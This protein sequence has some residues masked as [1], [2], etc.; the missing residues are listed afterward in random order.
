MSLKNVFAL[1]LGGG[2][3]VLTSSRLMYLPLDGVAFS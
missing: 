3:G 2:G 1:L